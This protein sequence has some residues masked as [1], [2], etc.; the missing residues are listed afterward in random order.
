M[1]LFTTE[2][3]DGQT[4]ACC[5]FRSYSSCP[6]PSA[7]CV[8]TS[9]HIKPGTDQNPCLAPPLDTTT[10]PP[11]VSDD[12]TFD[13]VLLCAFLNV[14]ERIELPIYFD[15][16]VKEHYPH[17][18][19]F[20]TIFKVN[21]KATFEYNKAK[22]P[23]SFI[24]DDLTHVEVDAIVNPSNTQL[25]PGRHF[26]VSA[27]IFDVAGFQDMVSATQALSPIEP[28][29]AVITPG[30]K[31]PAKYVIHVANPVWYEGKRGELKGLVESYENILSIAK[32]H[33]LKSLAL[34][35]LSS[36][37]YRFPKDLALTTALTTIQNFLLNHPMDIYMVVYDKESFEL[38]KQI[39]SDVKDYLE[40][41]T[42]VNTPEETL[43]IP[44]LNELLKQQTPTF[45]DTLYNLI[46]DKNFKESHVY[47]NANIT[48]QHYHKMMKERDYQPKASTVLAL[49]V[50]LQATIEEATQLMKSAGFVFPQSKQDHVVY[51]CLM[52]RLF[53]VDEI[54]LILYKHH[55]P[56]IGNV[57]K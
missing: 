29:S 53:I 42:Q 28:F 27:R 45:S 14:S 36:G 16:L 38:S 48:K 50:G 35:L 51:V 57:V 34:P 2:F 24:R 40:T 43:Q 55:L 12:H 5:G 31:L 41:H 46:M 9:V 18:I 20:Y 52:K 49:C 47:K 44:D 32:D 13:V 3:Q 23:L 17:S 10:A 30:F 21:L 11:W 33:Q 54:N 7:A 4:S 39:A 25:F 56:L 15:V 1:T 22:M 37:Y 26:S 6:V 8:C 19:E